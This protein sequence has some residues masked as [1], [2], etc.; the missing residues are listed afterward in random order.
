[1]EHESVNIESITNDGHA[2]NYQTVTIAPQVVGDLTYVSASHE[3]VSGTIS[4]DW[5]V[6]EGHFIMDLSVPFNCQAKV[7]LPGEENYKIVQSG[8]YSFRKKN[9]L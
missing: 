6:E 2:N 1:M 9:T 3:T 7:Y 4:V 8:T 5:R